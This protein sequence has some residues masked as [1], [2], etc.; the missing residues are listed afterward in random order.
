METAINTADAVKTNFEKGYDM[1]PA[2]FQIP[3]RDQ[4]MLQCGWSLMT[5]HSKRKG[6]TPIR[7]PE[8]PVIEKNFDL[9]NI[10]A[11]TGERISE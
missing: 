7:P 9:H 10:N 1:L 11:W 3:V 2:K 5:F 4:I 8:I 6:D